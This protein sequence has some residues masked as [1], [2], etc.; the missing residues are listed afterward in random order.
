[1]NETE[2]TGRPG[3]QAPSV[4]DPVCGMTVDPAKTAHHAEHGG[5]PYHFCSAGC[6]AKFIAD[7]GRYLGPPSQP[8]AAPEGT[9]WTCP[10]HPEI[11]QDHPGA[12]P[13]CGMTLEPATVTA[14]AGPSPELASMTRRFWVGL[15]LSIP[16]LILEM[17][18][19]LFPA[20]HHIVPMAISVNILR[21]RVFS[22]AQPRSKNGQPAQRTTGVARAN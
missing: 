2:A 14:D 15:A 4:K 13:I 17:G 20:L 9:I 19:H 3:A 22:E 5:K 16:V 11:R 8:V 12:C 6:R 10:M 18:G 21:L 1:M 7:W